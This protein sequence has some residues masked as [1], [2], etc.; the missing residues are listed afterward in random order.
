VIEAVGY[1]AREREHLLRSRR[2]IVHGFF[3]HS[4]TTL[5]LFRGFVQ[6]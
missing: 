2:E 5:L 6:S 3:A 1:L 4:A